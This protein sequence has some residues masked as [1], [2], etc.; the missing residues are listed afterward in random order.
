[1]S[2]ASK[3]WKEAVETLCRASSHNTPDF[4]LCSTRSVLFHKTVQ[5]RMWDAYMVNIMQLLKWYFQRKFNEMVE[6]TK[7]LTEKKQWQKLVFTT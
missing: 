6:Y 4:I 3:K 5:E 1:M 7:S 2:Q